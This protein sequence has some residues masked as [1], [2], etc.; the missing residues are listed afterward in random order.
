MSGFTNSKVQLA[1][2]RGEIDKLKA[3]LTR[4]RQRL[5]LYETDK[6]KRRQRIVSRTYD[7]QI[8]D[9]LIEWSEEG[10]FLDECLANWGID[11]ETWNK[12]LAEHVTLR[13]AVGPSRSRAKA[14][15][16][17]TLREAL[18]TRTAFPVSLADRIISI[19]DRESGADDESASK[20]VSFGLCPVCMSGDGASAPSEAEGE[21]S[22]S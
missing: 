9:E 15:I 10:L 22:A 14:A 4:T 6:S 21:G 7:D 11:Q 18:K 1:E 19:V 2:A 20:L 16:L 3:E 13:Q 8:I 5:A 12:W 17:K